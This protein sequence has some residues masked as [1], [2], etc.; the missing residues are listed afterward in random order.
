MVT[1]RQKPIVD[2]QKRKRKE[3]KHTTSENHQVTKEDSK[4]GRKELQNNQ[5]TI[6]KTTIVRPYLSTITLKVNELNSLIKRHR[7]VE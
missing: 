3:S 4:R 2:T 5:K 1:K 6:N 7:V